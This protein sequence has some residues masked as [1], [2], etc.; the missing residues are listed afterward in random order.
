M[1]KDLDISNYNCSDL[2][3]LF[4][5]KKLHGSSEQ[6]ENMCK[7]IDGKFEQPYQEFYR[8]GKKILKHSL[9]K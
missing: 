6:T 9:K 2:M 8:K 3:K 7:K 5:I 4:K 1:S